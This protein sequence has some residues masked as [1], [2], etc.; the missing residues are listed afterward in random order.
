MLHTKDNDEL[1]MMMM[2]GGGVA[3]EKYHVDG[4]TDCRT[5]VTLTAETRH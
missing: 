2:F 5:G 4:D 1:V 3:S